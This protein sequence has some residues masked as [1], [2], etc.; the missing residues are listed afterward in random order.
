MYQVTNCGA[1]G[2]NIRCR[3][4]IKATP[5]GMMVLGNQVSVT[6]EVSN[7]LQQYYFWFYPKTDVSYGVVTC[8]CLHTCVR[9]CVCAL[10]YGVVVCACVHACIK[11]DL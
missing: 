2:H 9:A 7:F 1:S 10:C 11:A 3:A 4:S 5:I 8:V 6:Q